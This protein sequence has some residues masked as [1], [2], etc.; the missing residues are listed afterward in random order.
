MTAIPFYKNYY[1]CPFC[2]YEWD[3]AWSCMCDDECP[4]CKSRDISPYRSELKK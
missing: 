2:G 1:K 4:E 3:S